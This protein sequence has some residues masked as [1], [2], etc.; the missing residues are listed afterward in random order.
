MNHHGIDLEAIVREVLQ[1]LYATNNDSVPRVP[2]DAGGSQP[3][4]LTLS[5][6][7]I[8][9]AELKGK[10]ASV[11]YLRVPAGAIVTP[12]AHDELR[13]HGIEIRF[14]PSTSHLA[15]PANLV[16]ATSLTDYCP[17]TLVHALRRDG[18][19]IEQ[20][21]RTGMTQVVESLAD[22]TTRGGRLATLLTDESAPALC[23]AN[24][25]PG[26]RAVLASDPKS[27]DKAVQGV[28]ANL[29]IVEPRTQSLASLRRTLAKFVQDGPRPCPVHYL[30]AL[31]SP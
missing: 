16:M 27:T 30:A 29:L 24:R 13:Q 25:R 23:L 31:S 8:S 5:N 1:R 20:V 26:V 21:A 7:V 18:I 2:A 19:A 14:Q 9:L 28:G 17:A 6:R 22:Q 15:T 12:A 11:R 10:L 3:G 4:E